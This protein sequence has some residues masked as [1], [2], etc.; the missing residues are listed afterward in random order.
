[1]RI[2]FYEWMENRGIVDEL[3]NRS[4]GYFHALKNDKHPNNKQ[5][6]KPRTFVNYYALKAD[7]SSSLTHRTLKPSALSKFPSRFR[8]P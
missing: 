6:S 1:M 3:L 8:P 7:H 2:G 4:A 5:S